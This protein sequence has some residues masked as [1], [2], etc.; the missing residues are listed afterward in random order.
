MQLNSHEKNRWQT[1]LA[2]LSRK[3]GNSV[4]Q[5]HS[6]PNSDYLTNTK[7]FADMTYLKEQ[8]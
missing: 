4:I 5:I 1:D 2:T 8:C 3:G 7:N 6:G